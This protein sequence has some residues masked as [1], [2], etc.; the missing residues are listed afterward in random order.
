MNLRTLA[1]VLVLALLAGFTALNWTAFTTPTS[2][3]LGFAV[4]Q[5]PLGLVMLM[6]CA[7]LA[8]LFLAYIVFQQAGVILE[9][10]RMSKE[11]KSQRELADRAEASRF[12]ELRSYLA[13]ELARLATRSDANGSEAKARI[14]RLEDALRE[15]LSET[16]RTLAAYVGEVEDK[17]DRLL[18]PRPDT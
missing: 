4:V 3:S 18:P 9:A 13:D 15:R 8:A 1:V 14:E 2:L 12:T 11:L 7:V 16:E 17:L 10:R 6:V 5:A